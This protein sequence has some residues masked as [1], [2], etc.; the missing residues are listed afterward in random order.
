MQYNKEIKEC[1]FS[2]FPSQMFDSFERLCA[3]RSVFRLDDFHVYWCFR[4]TAAAVVRYPTP[5]F[6]KCSSGFCNFHWWGS[7]SIFAPCWFLWL[8]I[9]FFKIFSPFLKEPKRVLIFYFLKEKNH[10][11]IWKCLLICTNY[12]GQNQVFKLITRLSSR[13]ESSARVSVLRLLLCSC[14]CGL[15][16][17]F[18]TFLCSVSKTLLMQPTFVVQVP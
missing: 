17:P 10:L 18:K 2:F 16:N 7:T 13:F 6:T 12:L 4:A 1:R 5:E 3:F 14:S 8:T 15:K 11:Q 9:F